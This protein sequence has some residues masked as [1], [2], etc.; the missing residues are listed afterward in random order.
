MR[1]LL[2]TLGALIA[3]PGLA[4]AGWQS[5]PGS[6]T[7]PDT[8]AVQLE[9]G[10][11]ICYRHAGTTDPPR[12]DARRCYAGV[13]VLYDGQVDGT[14]TDAEGQLYRCACADVFGV[15]CS[16]TGT[17]GCEKILTDTDADG[18]VN[19]VTLNGSVTGHRDAIYG[20]SPDFLLWDVTANASSRTFEVKFL[21]RGT[22]D[23]D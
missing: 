4:S 2:L 20:V 15:T 16:D 12:V 18:S 11:A 7:N 14:N 13:D 17:T 6:T 22:P 10:Q 8:A 19:D 1:S 21:C 9:A 5:C 23:R 3:L